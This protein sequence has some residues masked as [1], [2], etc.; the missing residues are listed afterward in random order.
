MSWSLKAV[1]G[2]CVQL[3]EGGLCA[4]DIAEATVWRW[5]SPRHSWGVESRESWLES[6]RAVTCV[7]Q[8]SQA[9]GS[10]FP[11]TGHSPDSILAEWS[12]GGWRCVCMRVSVC[13]CL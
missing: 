7:A 2:S 8:P 6:G 4:E 1:G 5:S 12:E 10:D 9:G 11:G 3:E 13:V